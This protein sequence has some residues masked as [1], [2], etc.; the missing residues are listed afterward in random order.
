MPESSNGTGGHEIESILDRYEGRLT[1]YAARITGDADAARDV[2]QDVFLRL[3][4][5]QSV[6]SN[7]RLAPWLYTVCRRRALDARRRGRRLRPL[8]D[9]DSLG[10]ASA[11]ADPAGVVENRD[12]ASTARQAL[13]QLPENQQEVIRLRFQEGLSYKEIAEV[14]GRSVNHVGVLI[15]NAIKV[16]RKTLNPPD[17]C[18]V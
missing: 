4:R 2:V 9:A 8:G 17:G 13:L 14:T 3:C 1:R 7:G 12:G 11:D 5:E 18:D 10:T 16:I 6:Q 15:H